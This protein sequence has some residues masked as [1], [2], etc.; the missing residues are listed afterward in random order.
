[1]IILHFN[2]LQMKI[3]IKNKKI[4]IGEEKKSLY[5]NQT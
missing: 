1:M 3:V 4:T 5:K 2:K